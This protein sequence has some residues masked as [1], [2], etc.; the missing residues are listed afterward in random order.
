MGLKVSEGL[1]SASSSLKRLTLALIV[2]D[3]LTTVTLTIGTQRWTPISISLPIA[4]ALWVSTAVAISSAARS[5]SKAKSI[6]SVL[7]SLCGGQS[8]YY[9]IRDSMAFSCRSPGVSRLGLCLSLQSG[10]LY[11]FS[12]NTWRPAVDRGDYECVR[13]YDGKLA[14]I[15]EVT[16][17][18][19]ILEAL[20]ESGPIA[21]SGVVALAEVKEKSP[22][23]LKALAL[24]L[25]ETLGERSSASR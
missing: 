24:K 1:S 19:G 3:L 21:G 9:A 15:G 23:T 22:D 2:V 13:F 14:Q 17:Y 20:T 16:V 12:V 5:L 6:T 18:E 7:G 4:L 25:I 11:A 10:K 8:K